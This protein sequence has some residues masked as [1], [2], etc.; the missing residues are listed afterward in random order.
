MPEKS[1]GLVNTPA[2][3]K[4][5]K[6][7]EKMLSNFLATDSSNL[8]E[9]L[10]ND[11]IVP[12]IKRGI[13]S[14]VDMLLYGKTRNV[15]DSGT[16][17]VNNGKTTSYNSFYRSTNNLNTSQNSNIPKTHETSGYRNLAFETRGDAEVVLRAMQEYIINFNIVSAGDMYDMAKVPTDNYTLYDYGW[18]NLDNVDIIRDGG[19]YVINL[20][21]PSPIK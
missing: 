21:K 1:K 10:I 15:N 4:K 18:T 11:V 13:S 16:Y 17:Y 6:S 7:L 3:V 5:D 9:Y 14:T 12:L 20:P 8:K 19:A 2:K